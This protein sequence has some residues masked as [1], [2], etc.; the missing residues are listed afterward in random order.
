MLATELKTGTVFKMNGFPYLVIKYEHIK[1]GR[2]S[3]NVKLRIRNI[4]T[5]QVMD[6][7]CVSTEKFED[8]DVFRKNAQY[9]YKDNNY[10]F[11][12]PDSFEQFNISDQLLGDSAKF[13]Q[14]GQNVQVQYFEGSP[15]S[16][17]LPITMVFEITY[18]EPGYKGNTVTNTF[19]DA[20]IN[21]GAVVKVPTFIKIGDKVKIDTRDGSYI[22]KA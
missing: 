13:L 2:G 12:D 15:I 3:A 7:G 9:L 8:A 17:D 1:V 14:E 21:T 18:T 16:I 11:M 5:G 4:I 19:K 20:T 10:I 6:K 22:S